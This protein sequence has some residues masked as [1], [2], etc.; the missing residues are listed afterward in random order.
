[1]ADHIPYFTTPN[2]SSN[3]LRKG[4]H[5]LVSCKR[6]IH[7]TAGFLVMYIRIIQICNVS[8]FVWHIEITCYV[9]I[10]IETEGELE[11]TSYS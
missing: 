3:D 6:H 9:Y 1:M 4:Q 7:V 10:F 2:I 8:L 5:F 11:G